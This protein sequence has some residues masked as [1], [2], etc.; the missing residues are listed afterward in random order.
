MGRNHYIFLLLLP[1]FCS[2]SLNLA[3]WNIQQINI[4]ICFTVYRFCCINCL[5]LRTK[6]RACCCKSWCMVCNISLDYCIMSMMYIHSVGLIIIWCPFFQHEIYFLAPFVLHFF[7]YPFRI[8]SIAL[9]FSICFYAFPIDRS[10]HLCQRKT[11][12]CIHD[13][14]EPPVKL[15]KSGDLNEKALHRQ[16]SQ[17]LCWIFH[18][19]KC[20]TGSHNEIAV[21]ENKR[22][23]IKMK[24]WCAANRNEQEK[25]KEF[26]LLPLS[27]SLS[28]S[29]SSPS[30]FFIIREAKLISSP[31]H[32]YSLKVLPYFCAHLIFVLVLWCWCC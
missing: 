1:F 11:A 31:L 25:K 14:R 3:M 18:E 22:A 8:Q 10:R 30:F 21:H 23:A 17:W 9:Y 27:H 2:Q 13:S 29:S 20:K 5:L 24:Q 28:S 19:H 7:P 16:H 12:F 4:M 15:N 26:S 32:A 6:W